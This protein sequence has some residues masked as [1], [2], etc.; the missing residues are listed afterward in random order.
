MPNGEESMGMSQASLCY[1]YR[2]WGSF[3][4]RSDRDRTGTLLSCV[5]LPR[6]P[7]KGKSSFLTYSILGLFNIMPPLAYTLAIQ[8]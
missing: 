1:R 5:A 8:L 6:R 7:G 3:G 2:T 4:S